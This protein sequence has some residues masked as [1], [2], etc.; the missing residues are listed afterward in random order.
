[1]AR[2]MDL[3]EVCAVDLIGQW[4]VQVCER[5]YEFEALTVIYTVTNL[6]DLVRIERKDLDH[7]M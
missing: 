1:M 7:I 3:F 4:T 2:D 6:V 5:P